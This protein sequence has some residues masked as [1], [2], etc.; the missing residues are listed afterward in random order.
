MTTD[1]IKNKRLVGLFL[2]GCTLFN[3]PILNLFNLDYFLFHL[4]LIYFY[5]FTVWILL[6]VAIVFITNLRPL[7]PNYTS[8]KVRNRGR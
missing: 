5:M 2:L 3:Y 4:P 8:R 7:T 6:I 1:S